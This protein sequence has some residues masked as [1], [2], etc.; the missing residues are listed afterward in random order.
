MEREERI[1]KA[2]EDLFY[3]RSFGDV[4]V[5]EIGARAGMSGPALYRHFAGKDE[6]LATLFD[7]AVDS[8]LARVPGGF[9]DPFEE[10]EQLVRAHAAFVIEHRKLASVRAREDRSLPDRYRRRHRRREAA[11]TRRWV[12]TVRRCYPSATDDAAAAAV[13]IALGLLN[14]VGS[15]RATSLDPPELNDLVAEMVLGGFVSLGQPAR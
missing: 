15:W 14:S 7:Q 3:D 9:D 2:A 10:L 5:D 13:N 6:I 12:D 8:L 1:L 4:G 11:Y